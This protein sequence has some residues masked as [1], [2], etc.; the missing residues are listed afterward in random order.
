MDRRH[1]LIS[2]LVYQAT[3]EELKQAT[4]WLKVTKN[5]VWYS[6]LLESR[7]DGPP[8]TM[9]CPLGATVQAASLETTAD[10][11]RRPE[12]LP[13]VTDVVD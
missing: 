9:Q 1:Q 11:R 8:V 4:I 13:T 2:A 12:V 3:V 7:N 6:M 5:R 10:F